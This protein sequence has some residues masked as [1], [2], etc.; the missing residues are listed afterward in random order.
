MAGDTDTKTPPPQKQSLMQYARAWGESPFP[1]TLLATL[2]AAQHM[3]P[4][5][6]LPMLFPPALLFTTYLNLLEYKVDAAGV[7]AAWSGLYLL[8]AAKRK[9]KFVQKW[10]ARGIVRGGAMGL[11]FANMVSGGL[12]YMLGERRKRGGEGDGV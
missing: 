5:Q 1:P 9:Q 2:I 12:V 7:S 10:G 4:F 3:R 6:P 11:G 8:L